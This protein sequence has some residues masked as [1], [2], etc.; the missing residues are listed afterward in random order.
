ML[1]KEGGN[2][3]PGSVKGVTSVDKLVKQGVNKSYSGYTSYKTGDN[4]P[5]V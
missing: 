3:L 4:R 2:V 1:N 5:H